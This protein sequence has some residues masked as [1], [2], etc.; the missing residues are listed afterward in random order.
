MTLTEAIA[1]DNDVRD[2]VNVIHKHPGF[3]KLRIAICCYP[4]KGAD[5]TNETCVE[6]AHGK[7]LG[8]NYVFNKIEEHATM[9]PA[10]VKKPSVPGSH[11]DPD[12]DP[13]RK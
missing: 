5:E 10:P 12:L 13:S 1:R 4:E 8:K 6:V 11:R 2:L 3:H 9:P 7:V